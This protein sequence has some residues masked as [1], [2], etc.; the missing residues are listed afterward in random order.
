MRWQGQQ[1]GVEDT[2]ALPGM[3]RMDGL[4]R[5]VTTPE[6]AGMTFHEVLCKSALNRVPGVSAMPFDW[7]VNPYRGC[8]HA[9][10]YCLSPDTLILKADGRQVPLSE[11]RVGDEIIGTEKGARYRQYVRTTVR[12]KWTTRKR[13]HRVTLA[14]GT[15]I[16]GSA[17]HRFL[18]ERGW[19]H[20]TD[21]PLAGEQRPHLTVSNRLQ[22]FGTGARPYAQAMGPDWRQGYLTGMVRGDAMILHKTYD[23]GNRVR[24]IHRFRLA[25]ADREALDLSKE[26]LEQIGIV[27]MVRPFPVPAHRRPMTALHTAKMRDVARIEDYT[28]IPSTRSRDWMAGFLGG[29]FD[30]E[31]S[32][33]RGILRISNANEELLSLTEEAFAAFRFDAVRE[34]ARPNGVSKVRLRGGLASRQRFFDIARPSITRKLNVCGTAVK[35]SADLRVVNIEDIGYDIDMIDI[36]TDTEDFVANGV[37][38][39]NCFARKTHEYLDLDYGA[40]FDSQIVVK[41]NVAEVL[42]TELRRGSWAREPVMLGTNTDPY[43]RAEGR[44]RLMPDIVGALTDNGT[45]FSILTKGTLLRRDLPLLTEAAQQVTVSLAMSIAVFDDALQRSIEPGTPSAEARLET[46][47]AATAAGFRVTVFLMPVMPHLTD[48]VA[49]LDDALAR[50]RAAGAARVVY[51]A[52]HLRPGAKQWFFEWLEREHPHLVSS[53]RGLYPG[54]STSAPKAYRTWLGKRMRPLLRMHRLDGWDEDDHPRG[55]PQPGLA[56]RTAPASSLGPVRT[57]GVSASTRPRVAPASE[58]TLF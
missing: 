56:A 3:E 52:L 30:A 33:S 51:G 10:S 15:E 39:H 53:Y 24:A 44:Y 22:G 45:P 21:S 27:T 18:T 35:T 7:T 29:I 6:F 57:V 37:I 12:A 20:V 32:C 48:S 4:V 55:R 47:R 43:Q 17:D 25:L 40:D 42:R 5:S 49:A 38:S 28:A 19:K 14:D 26:L 9:C 2:A 58:P 34:P 50:I 8:S 41:V 11:I 31:G 1:L 36:T 54:V 13:L 23:D 16:E 46:I